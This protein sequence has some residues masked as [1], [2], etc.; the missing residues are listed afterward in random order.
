MARRTRQ[1]SR[2]ETLRRKQ[3]RQ[4]KYGE[5]IPVRYNRV[6]VA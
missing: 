4:S 3:I 2:A 5:Y 6:K 1:E